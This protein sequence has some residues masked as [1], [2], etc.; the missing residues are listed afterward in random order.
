MCCTSSS[1]TACNNSVVIKCRKCLDKD[2]ENEHKRKMN[3]IVE[4]NDNEKICSTCTKVYELTFFEGINGETKTCENCREQNKKADVKRDKNHVNELKRISEQK[5][6]RK[7]VKTEYYSP[8]KNFSLDVTDLK[9]G[10][11]WLHCTL[12]NGYQSVIN[13]MK[14]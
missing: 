12:E 8:T 14:D 3:K 10:I 5:Q 2:N 6:D 1:I 11:Y 4:I 13:L 9:S 7:I